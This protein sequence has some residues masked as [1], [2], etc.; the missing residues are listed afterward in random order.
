V[1]SWR[2]G[3]LAV[4]R[5]W[6]REIGLE[7][8]ALF[9]PGAPDDLTEPG[10][11]P[12][13]VGFKEATV[14]ALLRAGVEV[15]ASFDDNAAV[16]AAL[17]DAGVPDVRLVPHLIDVAPWEWSA[18]YVGAPRTTPTVRAAAATPSSA[19]RRSGAGP[20]RA[21]EPRRWERT[22][23]WEDDPLYWHDADA[24]RADAVHAAP[25]TPAAGPLP[26]ARAVSPG[27]RRRT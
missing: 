2:C 21:L 12:G 10:H 26:R 27:P 3:P 4:T 25:S 11:R 22:L 13:Q 9:L 24:L 19:R 6:L 23:S 16:L 8:A 18:G 7:V 14:R 1:L 15:M 5:A 17:H 20:R